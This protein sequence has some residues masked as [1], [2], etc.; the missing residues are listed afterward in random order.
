M[1]GPILF[2]RYNSVSNI[3]YL[4]ST[5]Y[6]LYPASTATTISLSEHLPL[7]WL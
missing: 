6:V 3:L 2:K 7:Y 4:V 1:Q 5:S